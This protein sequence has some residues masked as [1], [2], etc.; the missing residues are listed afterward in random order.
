M[1]QTSLIEPKGG[2]NKDTLESNHGF[3]HKGAAD[4]AIAAT[5]ELL[6]DIRMAA[7]DLPFLEYVRAAVHISPSFSVLFI[8]AL[9]PPGCWEFP[10]DPVGLWVS[11]STPQ[12][13]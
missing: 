12:K 11:S 2:I 10:E 4:L 6:E 8:R 9:S 7:G 13:A 1:D 3:L 5:G